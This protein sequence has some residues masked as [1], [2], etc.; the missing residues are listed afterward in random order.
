MFTGI[1]ERSVPVVSITQG[2]GFRRLTLA[3][4]WP[5]VKHGESVAVNGVC[6]TVAEISV[7][8]ATDEGTRRNE[9][10][11]GATSGSSFIPHP[12]SLGSTLAF[13]VIPE[14]LARTNLGLLK[15]GATVHVERSLA[16]P[17]ASPATF[18][19]ATSMP[20]RSCSL[21]ATKTMTSA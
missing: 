19:R 8:H 15:P 14:T 9:E 16:H 3:A 18:F 21:S 1:V 4:D 10:S 5:N 17:T 12:S 7:Q 2:T 6:L 13:N 11:A 20:R